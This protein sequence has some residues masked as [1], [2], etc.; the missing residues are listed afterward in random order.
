MKRQRNCKKLASETGTSEEQARHWLEKQAIW[1]IYMPAPSD[2]SIVRPM[3]RNKS[4]ASPNKMHQVDPSYLLHNIFCT[5]NLQV[6]VDL[7]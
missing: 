5:K 1:Q 6:H 7:L 3:S 2:A 4:I